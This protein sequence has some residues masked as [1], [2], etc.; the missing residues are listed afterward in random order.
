MNDWIT[1]DMPW[2]T[3]AS[4]NIETW[5]AVNWGAYHFHANKGLDLQRQ[6]QR[7]LT[8]E[9]DTTAITLEISENN[10]KFAEY[11]HRVENPEPSFRDIAKVGMVLETAESDQVL[12]GS[13]GYWDET[14]PNNTV[15]VRYKQVW[16]VT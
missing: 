15:I 8:L 12:L 5:R 1:C 11:K 14:I 16:S 10:G 4:A 2:R 3:F 13:A 7:M 6:Y 9:E